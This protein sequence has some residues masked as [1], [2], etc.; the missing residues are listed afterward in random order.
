MVAKDPVMRAKLISLAISLT[1]LYR[2]PD[3]K[4]T[5]NWVVGARSRA[6]NPIFGPPSR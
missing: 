2:F 4:N 5:E 1:R 6:H 3:G